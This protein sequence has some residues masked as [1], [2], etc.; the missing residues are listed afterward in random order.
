MATTSQI[1]VNVARGELA[2]GVKEIPDGSNTSPRIVQYQHATWLGGTGWAWCAA[3]CDWVYRDA[4]YPFPF[5]SAGAY[6][7]L[8]RA[9]K[10]GWAATA[11]QVGCVAV[12]NLGAGH[13]AIVEKFDGSTVTTIDGN[14]SNRVGRHTRSR[15]TV[16]GYVV[17]P[18]LKSGP[19]HIP[20][21]PKKATKPPYYQIVASING[22]RQLVVSGR[23]Y[24]QLVAF[25]PK[26]LARWKKI[27][28]V[29]TR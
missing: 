4:G 22:H 1:I 13:A 20:T 14:V 11:P 25:I 18:R 19:V 5:P 29:K 12:F 6:D 15:S 28:I 3:F 2:K 16:R 27:E 9:Q 10:A 26:A 24:A 17:H 21:P 7:F 8:A 23:P